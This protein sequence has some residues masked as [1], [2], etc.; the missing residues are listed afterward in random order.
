MLLNI[1]T[2]L[3]KISQFRFVEKRK[4][5]IDYANGT[6]IYNLSCI[7]SPSNL[8]PIAV[9]TQSIENKLAL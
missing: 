4:F 5:L 9:L 2:L 6:H 7:T 8:I 3:L 1:K